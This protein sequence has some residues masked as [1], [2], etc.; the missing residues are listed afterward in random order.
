MTARS[1]RIVI[2]SSGLGHVARGIE[3]WADDLAAALDARGEQVVLCKGAGA[4]TR[5]YERVVPCLRREAP[6]TL[7][8][9]RH[10]PRRLS[11]R[12]GLGS[13]YRIEQTTFALNLVRLLRREPADVL[14]VQDPQV[15]AIAQRAGRMGL[16]RAR[17][18]LAHGT[19][20][21]P[22]FLARIRY[23]QHLAPWHLEQARAGGV[24]RPTWTAIPNFIDTDRFSPGPGDALRSELGIPA[25]ARVVLTAAAIS[26]GHK[27]IDHLIAEFAEVRRR[28]PELPVWL[29]VAGGWEP[30]TDELVAE[31]TRRLGDRVRF[32]VRFP[33]QRMPDLYRAA[34]VF[35][36]CSLF[37]MMPIALIEATASGLP[38][39]VNGHPI[40]EWMT[41]P[42]RA[43]RWARPGR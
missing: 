2:A 23:L 1:P 14:H 32:L 28:A 37:E 7:R 11:W 33:R 19:E 25:G 15:A 40:L 41:G 34:D 38:C 6:A 20:E 42:G 12:V 5:P 9:L 26:R 22:A 29:V 17:T 43:S 8:L 21:P 3:A 35:V 39:V 4:V 10:L 30:E 18:V 31:G 27:R 36:L 24:W 13:G 16:I